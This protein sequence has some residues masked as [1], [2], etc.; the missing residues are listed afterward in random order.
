MLPLG[1]DVLLLAA[2]VAV[3]LYQGLAILFAYQMPLLHPLPPSST[4]PTRRKVSVVI[5]ARNEELDLPSTL[6]AILAQDYPN[7]EVVVVDGGS[8]DRTREIAKTFAP[9]VRLFEE[10]PL[11]EGWVGKNWACSVGARATDGEWVLFLDADV[12]THPAA[13]R[14]VVDWAE[15]EDASL[16]SIGAKVEMV[17]FWERTVLPFF[18]Q[19]VLTYFRSPRV[20]RRDSRA[21]LANG[22][23]LLVRR[24]DYV[25]LG[26]HEAVRGLVLEDVALA[27]RFRAAGRTL[28]LAWAPELARTRMYRTRAEMREGLLKNIHGTDYSTARQLGFMV[29]LVGLFLLPLGLLPLGVATQD[30]YLAGMGAFLY[31]ALFGKHVA[32]TRSLGAP[33]IYGLL[34]PVAVGFYLAVVATSIRRGVRH[35][36]IVWK[37]RSYRWQG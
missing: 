5:A 6:Q 7:L 24:D 32:F 27:R 26:G 17:G 10:P 18:V 37:G 3:L 14:T 11:P 21:A 19:M 12:G 33:W 29:G 8:T 20:N 16:A 35:R 31:L 1:V 15:R 30:P 22:Q 4:I 34:F 25:Q 13:V 9:R 2:A 36:P 28:R 23:F